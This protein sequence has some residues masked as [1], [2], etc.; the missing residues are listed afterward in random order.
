LVPAGRGNAITRTVAQPVTTAN[1]H[2]TT[3]T[4]AHGCSFTIPDGHADTG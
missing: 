3:L 4:V 2:P 1:R